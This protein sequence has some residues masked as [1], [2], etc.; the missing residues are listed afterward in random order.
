MI[1][2]DFLAFLLGKLLFFTWIDS[3][4]LPLNNRSYI[5]FKV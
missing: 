4:N 1:Y 5:F 2:D 3:L